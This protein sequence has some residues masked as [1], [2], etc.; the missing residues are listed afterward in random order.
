MKQFFLL[1]LFS[2][3]LT[4]C[5]FFGTVDNQTKTK[6]IDLARQNIVGIWHL[7]KISY[8]FLSAKDK[9]DSISIN[10]SSNGS[11]VLNNSNNIFVHNFD[12]NKNKVLVDNQKTVGKWNISHNEFLNSDE[13]NLFFGNEQ[14]RLEGL[15]VYKKGNQY[16]I[17]WFFND[18]DTG[19]RLRFLK[20]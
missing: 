1:I 18:P 11:F 20:N 5:N 12:L 19:D 16:Q 7:D 2:L 15:K 6:N 13:L 4:S 3:S 17:I 9:I 10:F 14:S 8:K